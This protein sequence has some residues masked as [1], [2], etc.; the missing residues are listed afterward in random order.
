[1]EPTNI[2]ARFMRRLPR[3]Q[4]GHSEA[5][6]S[7]STFLEEGG[8]LA[9]SAQYLITTLRDTVL[10]S[11]RKSARAEGKELPGETAAT[12]MAAS[13][14][15]PAVSPVD[16]KAAKAAAKAAEKEAKVKKKAEE[17]AAKA[18]AKAAKSNGA[19]IPDDGPP[20]ADAEG[21][22]VRAAD[23]PDD[24]PPANISTGEARVDPADDVPGDEV[25]LSASDLH[26]IVGKFVGANKVTVP[27]VKEILA[28]YGATR[29]V[30][31]PAESR[32]AV[33]DQIE[34]L[35]SV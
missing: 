27:Q 8:D 15:K 6:L 13:D 5:E 25:G 7:A 18:A 33:R 3:E 26:G 11:L 31:V 16:A 32:A 19:D 12:P 22:A 35:A 4:Y 28:A 21:G 2:T 29:T 10:N 17:K 24:D 34:A 14:D 1:M 9:V 23:I 30:D 20:V